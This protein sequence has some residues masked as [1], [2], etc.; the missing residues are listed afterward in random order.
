MVPAG[1]SGFFRFPHTPHLVWLG[2]GTP[3]DDKVL[4]SQAATELL[5]STVVVEEKLDGANLGISVAPDGSLRA[6]NRG[7]C[8]TAPYRGQFSRLDGWLT[9]R[10]DALFDALTESHVLFGEWCAAKHSIDYNGLP[11]WFLVFDIYDRAESRFWS[12]SRRDEL[13]ATLG[14]NSVPTLFTGRTTKNQ[15]I[16]MVKG[17]SSVFHGG[18]AEGIVIRSETDQWLEQR[19]KIVHPDFTQA[20]GE[21][22][23]RH[24]LEWN[25]LAEH[26]QAQLRGDS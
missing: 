17:Q 21:H 23:S 9:Q 8:L 19:A 24:A 2:D 10:Q 15:L 11:D 26:G 1:Q 7:Q 12:T 6:Q 22:W 18:S 20:I 5:N 14:L 3:R 25:S 4:E 16:D 13:V